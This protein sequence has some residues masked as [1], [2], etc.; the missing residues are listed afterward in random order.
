MLTDEIKKQFVT[1]V[2]DLSPEN[3]TCDGEL[4][5][6]KV[7]AKRARLLKEWGRLEREAGERVTETRAY[8][9]FNL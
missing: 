5:P 9:W 1:L 7:K 3:L 6:S 2:C 8:S 4:S